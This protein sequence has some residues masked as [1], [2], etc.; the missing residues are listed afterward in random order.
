MNIMQYRC[1]FIIRASE[2]P[3]YINS[4]TFLYWGTVLGFTRC[5][6]KDPW[7]HDSIKLHPI[8]KFK[9]KNLSMRNEIGRV[10]RLI[11]CFIPYVKIKASNCFP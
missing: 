4:D 10:V 3:E 11:I 5:E 8:A 7:I 9:I 1:K 6:H 2:K